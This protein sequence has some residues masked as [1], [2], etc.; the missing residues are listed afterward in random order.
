[1]EG[2]PRAFFELAD[3]DGRTAA[4]WRRVCKAWR[5]HVDRVRALTDAIALHLIRL[6]NVYDLSHELGDKLH[7]LSSQRAARLLTAI[8]ET[9]HCF[10][11]YM[12]ND[13]RHQTLVSPYAFFRAFG[14]YGEGVAQLEDTSSGDLVLVN[15]FYK[16]NPTPH[17]Y[18]DMTW[19]E[20]I[21]FPGVVTWKMFTFPMVMGEQRALIHKKEF[22]RGCCFMVRVRNADYVAPTTGA[23]AT[24][25][26][27]ARKRARTCTPIEEEANERTR[28]R[29]GMNNSY[30]G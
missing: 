26:K 20:R 27:H 14:W 11:A 5:H 3:V 21:A 8:L 24:L 10:N 17:W 12:L 16:F 18:D 13:M 25:R 28:L 22:H 29:K 9:S 23:N 2:L 30:Y 7:Y 19:L 15:N 1:M 4:R 6:E